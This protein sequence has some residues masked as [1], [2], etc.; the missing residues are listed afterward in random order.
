MY[1]P[2]HFRMDDVGVRALLAGHRAGD[3]VTATSRGLIA[4]FLPFVHEQTAGPS[5]ALLGHLA[6]HNEQWQLPVLGEAMVILRGPD[7]YVSPTCYA[8]T[9]EHGRVVPTWNYVAAHVYG[10]LVVHDDA[11]WTREL[12][13]RLT[14]QHERHRLDPW[15]VSD[16]PAPFIA[17]QIRAIVGVELRITRVEAKAKLSQNR[18]AADI[19]GVVRDARAGGNAEIADAVQAARA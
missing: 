16:A 8:S 4:T 15:Q 1:L 3:L 12:V 14:H 6:R 13:D 7:A 9:A 11:R 5:G 18:S 2:E 19:D 17:G 10:E